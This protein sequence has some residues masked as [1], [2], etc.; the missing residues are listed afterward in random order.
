[1]NFIQEIESARE[2]FEEY[3]A[4]LQIDL[5]FQSFDKELAGLPGQYAPP[6]GLR[7]HAT[8][9]LA[10]KNG[11]GDQTLPRTWLPGDSGLLSQ[12]RRRC[13]IHGVI[14]LIVQSPNRQDAKTAKKS[15]QE[16][17]GRSYKSPTAKVCAIILASLASWRLD[18]DLLN[19]VSYAKFIGLKPE[20]L[21]SHKQ[22]PGLKR[23]LQPEQK[24]SK[25]QPARNWCWQSKIPASTSFI[26][27]VAM[28]GVL[29]AGL[30]FSKETRKKCG[31]WS[32]TV[33]RWKPS[34][35]TTSD[36]RARS[37]SV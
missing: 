28:P 9:Y 19:S 18:H 31:S 37:I 1:M 24:L 29:P 16:T 25:H 5:C 11:P 30:R 15:K 27:A 2:L 35:P 33:W 20:S 14:A 6:D 12:P 23:K 34:S 10:R 8:R 32:A 22:C 7:A 21:R 3:A 17:E 13:D 36:C 4:W 26:A